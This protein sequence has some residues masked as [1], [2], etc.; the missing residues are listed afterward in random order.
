MEQWGELETKPFK[1]IHFDRNGPLNPSS[2]S[3]TYC[4]VVEE[5]SSRL[6]GAYPV[7]DTGAQTTVNALENGSH[8]MVY[9]KKMFIITVQ[10]S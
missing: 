5:A 7:E 4:L 3:N 8:C 1:K 10:P 9:L 2:N 6:L